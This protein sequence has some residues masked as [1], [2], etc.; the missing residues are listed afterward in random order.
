ME[1]FVIYN[2][3]NEIMK[4]YEA[5]EVY[6]GKERRGLFYLDYF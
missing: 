4:K 1:S 3:S 2:I 6:G 5:G